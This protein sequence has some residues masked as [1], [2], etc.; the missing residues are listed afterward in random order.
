[1]QIIK[2]NNVRLS[3]YLEMKNICLSSKKPMQLQCTTFIMILG[4]IYNYKW[5]KYIII[6]FFIFV[7]FFLSLHLE[8]KILAKTRTIIK[9]VCRYVEVN[10][11][12]AALVWPLFNSLQ[13]FWPGLQVIRII[14]NT[15]CLMTYYVN[16]FSLGSSG[17]C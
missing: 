2:V 16:T 11:N 3:C 9:Y 5:Y 7:S 14:C 17:G 4:K 15:Y 6:F 10:M 13:A 12:S 1:M 8:V